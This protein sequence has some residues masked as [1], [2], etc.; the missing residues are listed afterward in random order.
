MKMNKKIIISSIIAVAILIGISFTSV[1]GYSSVRSTTGKESP[2]FNIRTNSAIGEESKILTSNYVG[3]GNTL[4]FPKRNDKAVMVQK[5]VDTIRKMDDKTLEKFISSLISYIKKDNRFNGIK[6]DEIREAIYL[7]RNSDESI[8]IYESDSNNNLQILTL[9]TC[10]ATCSCPI[11]S[12]H[13]N[14]GL[15]VC[16][17]L[18]PFALIFKIM[19]P[20]L[21]PIFYI[22]VFLSTF[23]NWLENIA[24]SFLLKACLT[25][26]ACWV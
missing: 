20:I 21:T 22:L 2:L 3:R 19:E 8:P 15:L 10:F 25:R 13:G 6:S 23:L 5:V 24:P 12:G 18:L 16:I 1:V 9:M 11:T 7:L 17:L 4:H 14:I 26:N